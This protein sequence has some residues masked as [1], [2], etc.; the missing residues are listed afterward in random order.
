MILFFSLV[1]CTTSLTISETVVSFPI[2]S[3]LYIIFPSWFIL[4]A[5]TLDLTSLNTGCDS[6]V[7]SDSSIVVLPSTISPSTAI[8]SPG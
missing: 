2:L 1:A 7:I 4:P 8:F 6:P 3:A 5:I